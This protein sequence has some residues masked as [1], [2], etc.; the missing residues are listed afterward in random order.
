[1]HTRDD[2]RSINSTQHL[3]AAL[4]ALADKQSDNLVQLFGRLS[5]RRYPLDPN[6]PEHQNS[7]R[8]LSEYNLDSFQAFASTPGVLSH[9]QA[10]ESGRFAPLARSL[11]RYIANPSSDTRARM[12]NDGVAEIK[13]TFRDDLQLHIQVADNNTMS[14]LG[15]GDSVVRRELRTQEAKDTYVK[16]RSDA[17]QALMKRNADYARLVDSAETT[18]HGTFAAAMADSRK[19]VASNPDIVY[20]PS[21]SLTAWKYMDQTRYDYRAYQ[22]TPNGAA[23]DDPLLAN[24]RDEFT[25]E[26]QTRMTADP[27]LA[28]IAKPAFGLEAVIRVHE[29]AK[30]EFIAKQLLEIRK[31]VKA[32]AAFESM[33]REEA[34]QVQQ[35]RVIRTGQGMENGDVFQG[36]A[37]LNSFMG[38]AAVELANEPGF[39]NLG[40]KE[41][42]R[43]TQERGLAKAMGDPT[44]AKQMPLVQT[45]SKEMLPSL[46]K[47][48]ETTSAARRE[49]QAS[50]TAVATTKN[51]QGH[52]R[53]DAVKVPTISWSDIIPNGRVL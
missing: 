25:R 27:A 18:A 22:S 4:W 37:R 5:K 21:K 23:V 45:L 13:G 30:D 16:V 38:M 53:G 48:Y 51:Y 40:S 35:A 15:L 36:S 52:N 49:S 10:Q 2:S 46:E 24:F 1:M 11:T 29:N 44:L 26:M 6:D 3:T 50:S 32:G 39:A 9:L 7:L 43:R 17:L 8:V 28:V 14:A 41:A 33:F 34:Q 47:A 19:Y 20:D 31:D 42:A 12:I